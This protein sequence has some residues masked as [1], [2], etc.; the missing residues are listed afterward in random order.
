MFATSQLKGILYM[1]ASTALFVL[2]DTFLKLASTE[3]PA[4]QLT[5]LRAVVSA[6][7]CGVAI[8]YWSQWR[9]ISGL[10]HPRTALRGVVEAF[11]AIFFTLGLA[12]LA[13]ADAFA[14]AQTVP[15]FLLLG[16]ALIYRDRLT[17]TQAFLAVVGFG[18]AML[19]A[20]PSF[21]GLSIGIVFAFGASICVASRDLVGRGIPNTIPVAIVAGATSVAIIAL[22]GVLLLFQGEWRK[23]SPINLFYISLA[24]LC[25]AIGQAAVVIA[26]RNAEAVTLAPLFY[27]F[28]VWSVLS[29]LVIWGELPNTTAML[30]IGL[31]VGSGLLLVR[32]G[33]RSND[34]VP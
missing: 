2:G 4:N 12:R 17:P 30:G 9:G 19:V 34:P 31:I 29:G 18:G 6:I 26:Y 14:I 5:F 20:Q 1:L 23:P 32:L 3:L 10:T 27:S 22:A 33:G 11:A 24:G 16:A 13:I 7:T 15:L 21:E 25:V 8:T 28:A